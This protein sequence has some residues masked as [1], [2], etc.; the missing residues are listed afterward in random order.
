MAGSGNRLTTG[1]PGIQFSTLSQHSRL[2]QLL[3][4]LLTPTSFMLRA[5]KDCSDLTYRLAMEFISRP[6]PGKLGVTWACEMGSRFQ[7]W[8]L[9][10]AIRIGCSRPCLGILMARIRNAGFF[11]QLMVES[12]G[13]RCFTKTRTPAAQMLKSIHRI[14]TSFTRRCGNRVL[15]LRRTVTLSQGQMGDCSSRPTVAIRGK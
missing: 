9:I 15:G 12:P 8:Q 10:R 14:P 1:E 5:V 2:E 7:R 6:M 4:P 11:V 13:K 3:Y